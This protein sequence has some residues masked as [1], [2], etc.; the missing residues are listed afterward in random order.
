MYQV[1]KEIHFCYGHRLLDYNGKCMHPHGHN[2]RVDFLLQS[3][4]FIQ[5]WSRRN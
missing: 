3:Y 2:A 5:R 4:I 1:T